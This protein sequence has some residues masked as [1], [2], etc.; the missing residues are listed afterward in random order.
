MSTSNRRTLR[1]LAVRQALDYATSGRHLAYRR[2]FGHGPRFADM[3]LPW[4]RFT[5]P[6]SNGGRVPAEPRRFAAKSANLSAG[7]TRGDTAVQVHR[8]ETI[9]QP[10]RL[11]CGTFRAI[12]SAWRSTG[13]CGKGLASDRRLG[14]ATS[15]SGKRTVRVK[16]SAVHQHDTTRSLY[17]W[18]NGGDPIDTF[19]GTASSIRSSPSYGRKRYCCFYRFS[20]QSTIDKLTTRRVNTLELEAR[21][22][23]YYRSKAAV[24][25]G[26]RRFRF[27]PAGSSCRFGPA[28]LHGFSL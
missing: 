4:L 1:N 18:T 25:A 22:G 10:W 16:G 6:R 12:P 23:L 8:K 28:S 11:P 17:A 15:G 24:G 9:T 3:A 5:T 13:F 20:F 26:P 19:Y 7:C 27:S 2:V 14:N 21:S